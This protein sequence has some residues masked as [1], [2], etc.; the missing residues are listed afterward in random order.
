MKQ[1]KFYIAAAVLFALAFVFH[2]ARGMLIFFGI[3]SLAI[4]FIIEKALKPK[5]E[6]FDMSNWGSRLNFRNIQRGFKWTTPSRL[7]NF[8]KSQKQKPVF[9][10]K[11]AMYPDTLELLGRSKA[12]NVDV[13]LNAKTFTKTM[14]VMGGMG[15]GKSFFFYQFFK[16]THAFMRIFVHDMKGAF[17]EYFYRKGKDWILNLFDERH[18]NWSI[19]AEIENNPQTVVSFVK[20]VVN[21]AQGED[22]K[23][24]FFSSSAAELIKD[25]IF[26]AYYNN[27]GAPDTVLWKAVF[28]E[29][30]KWEKDAAG[31]RT[32]QSIL[33]T[34]NLA[35]EIFELM[36]QHAD[37]PKWTI[38]QF[39]QSKDK[40][41][42]M[43]NIPELGEKLN[44]Y[45]AGF[46]AAMAAI[47]LSQPDTDE[48]LTFYLLDEWYTLNLDVDTARTLL[49]AIRS[50]GGCL[51][52]GAIFLRMDDKFMQQLMDSSRAMM[53][54][55][56]VPEG[57]TQTHISKAFG[58][59][60][61]EEKKHV[62]EG[63][64]KHVEFSMTK[65]PF[66]TNEQIVSMP[67]YH[68]LTFLGGEGIVYLGYTPAEKLNK[69]AKPFEAID[70]G[71]FYQDKYAKDKTVLTYQEKEIIY[72][73]IKNLGD[74]EAIDWL[75]NNG[76]SDV[77]IKELKALFEELGE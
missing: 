14:L 41:L 1:K 29:K 17:V 9:V 45:F 74:F 69:I 11:F 44:P 70:Q 73:A 42:F 25:W 46:T 35:F 12:P 34:A 32:K 13:S 58:E 19:F 51:A 27:Q 61:Y 39:L 47:H 53:F 64:N 7:R 10:D 2:G 50:K 71:K 63:K 26:G 36:A 4:G 62:G 40:N 23:K 67:P 54:V 77:N 43:L 22:G 56:N 31:D 37:K 68:H 18:V 38:K 8:S 5:I 30:A 55:F 3:V 57:E 65:A 59:I 24:D 52:I 16:N 20:G 6:I 33:G 66:L 21:S 60:Y 75:E 48:D 72:Q 76:Y 28:D 49:T 15:S